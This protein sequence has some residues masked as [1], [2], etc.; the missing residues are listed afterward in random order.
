MHYHKLTGISL[1]PNFTRVSVSNWFH[2]TS[3]RVH[4]ATTEALTSP[5]LTLLTTLPVSPEIQIIGLVIAQGE[6]YVHCH[7]RQDGWVNVGTSQV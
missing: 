4:V 7:F 2:R 6:G 5:H 3:L 1:I